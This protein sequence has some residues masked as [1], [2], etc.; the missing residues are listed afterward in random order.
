MVRLGI[1]SIN[2][3]WAAR[4]SVKRTVINPL[5][6]AFARSAFQKVKPGPE[7]AE[8]E[9]LRKLKPYSIWQDR[10][11]CM[12]LLGVMALL[13]AILAAATIAVVANRK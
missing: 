2:K 12:R 5:I 3:R 6:R 10:R 1:P 4:T 11:T 9:K 7:D 8:L 13:A